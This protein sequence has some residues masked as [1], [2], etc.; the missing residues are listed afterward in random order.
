MDF[1]A[2]TLSELLLSNEPNKMVYHL[3]NPV[4]Q[5][6]HDALS[7]VA[8]ELGLPKAGFVPFNEWLD[9]VCAAPDEGSDIV[10]AKK[11]EDFFRIDFEHMACGSIVL[12][13]KNT[14]DV[15]TALRKL[16]HVG[17]ELL[18]SYIRQWKLSGYLA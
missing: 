15:S 1:A 10:P 11:L 5:S 6:W 12:D 8:P 14:R 7:L 2:E 9:R 13:T 16:T 3:E 17:G 4:R 18:L